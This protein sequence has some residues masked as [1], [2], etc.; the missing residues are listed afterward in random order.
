MIT[1]KNRSDRP[2]QCRNYGA[3]ETPIEDPEKFY[4]SINN[5]EDKCPIPRFSGFVANRNESYNEFHKTL[6]GASTTGDMPSIPRREVAACKL[7]FQ[8]F[9]AI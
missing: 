8:P 6:G 7:I 5:T 3:D 4:R 1:G 2:P 9:M